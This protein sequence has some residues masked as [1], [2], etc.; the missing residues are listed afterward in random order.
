MAVV[1]GVSIFFG[2]AVPARADFEVQFSFGGATIT[3]D[4]TTGTYSTAGGASVSGATMNG[5]ALSGGTFTPVA[6]TM[7]I[8]G[9]VISPSGTTGGFKVNTTVTDSNSPGS[10][11]AT[12]DF[13]SLSIKNQ[14]GAS[15][16]LSVLNGDTGFT[17]PTGAKG[18]LESSIS[19]SAAAANGSNATVKWASFIDTTNAQ[20]GTQQGIAGE[21]VTLTIAHGGTKSSDLFGSVTPTPTPYSMTEQLSITL[22]NGD[23]LTDLSGVTNL[24]VPVPAGIA[25]VLSGMP[26]LG[27][28]W[29]RARRNKK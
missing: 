8:S 14:S 3:F 26:V 11:V 28:G 12:I 25:L 24:T 22:A 29:L 21:P 2:P 6:G 4:N 23:S 17:S 5:V 27:L 16:T 1:V 9:L 7:T 10:S 13:S 18:T 19:A 20:F 15:G